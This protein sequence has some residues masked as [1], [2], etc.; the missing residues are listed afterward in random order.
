M[1][2]RYL[3]GPVSAEFANDYLGPQRARGECLAFNPRG[4]V[5]VTLGEDDTWETLLGRLPQR[6]RPDFVALHLYYT[7]VPDWLWSAPVPLVGLAGDWNLQF[8]FLRRLHG[9]DLVFTDTR[10]V[11]LLSGEG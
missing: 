4:D 3:F 1:S 7:A 5:D 9:C 10:G 2:L 8:H 11:D 6:W